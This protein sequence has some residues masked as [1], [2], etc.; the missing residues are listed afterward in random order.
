MNFFTLELE[1][2]GFVSSHEDSL[3]FEKI[4]S[5]SGRISAIIIV[6]LYAM[7]HGT[8]SQ[9]DIIF[10]DYVFS[11]IFNNDEVISGEAKKGMNLILE[12]LEE[13]T[14]HSNDRTSE[15]FNL[16]YDT[17]SVWIS[18]ITVRNEKFVRLTLS[19]N[20]A[21]YSNSYLS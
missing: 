16:H 8:R 4:Q 7:N 17:E 18:C 3:F 20:G 5:N 19:D 10:L 15:Y 2:L 11:F 1:S 6:K 21:S 12:N 9:L 14:K 13:L